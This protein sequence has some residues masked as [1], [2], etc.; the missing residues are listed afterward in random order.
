MKKIISHPIIKS[1]IKSYRLESG[2]EDIMSFPDD[3]YEMDFYLRILDVYQ[4]KQL[5]KVAL[6]IWKDRSYI[7]LMQVLKRTN[8]KNLVKNAIILL[9]SL[10]EEL[11]IDL[12]D[13]YGINTKKLKKDEKKVFISKMK[14]EFLNGIPN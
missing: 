4:N 13:N 5:D 11:P 7:E 14:S 6:E 8:N 12:Y 9:L 2:S 3:E 1:K 10:F